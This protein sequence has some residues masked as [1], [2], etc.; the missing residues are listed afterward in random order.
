[1]E[2]QNPITVLVVDDHFL[3][4]MGLSS[5]L[6][7]EPDLQVV[8]EAANGPQAVQLFDEHRPDVTLIDLRLPGMTGVE[9]IA[10]I[11][12]LDPAARILAFSTYDAEEEIYRALQA[13]ARAYVPKGV[14]RDE[15]LEAIRAV[16]A[17]R[18]YLPSDVASR[19]AARIPCSDLSPREFEVLRLLVKGWR[20]RQIAT[21]LGI[22]EVTVKLHVSRILAKLGVSDRTEAA[23][24]ALQRGIVQIEP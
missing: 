4:R 18:Y 3:V 16:H 9:A 14:Q 21:T 11:R 19:L 6:G 8:A 15:L 7:A 20:N 23:T 24:T 1:M 10:K 17:G 5:T 12:A 13:G 2:T 22:T